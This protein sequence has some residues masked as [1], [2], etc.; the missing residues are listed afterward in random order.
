MECEF[1]TLCSWQNGQKK[2]D[3]KYDKT[4]IELAITYKSDKTDKTHIYNRNV[5][6]YI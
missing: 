4:D 5:K 2:T 1:V 6:Q 3:K